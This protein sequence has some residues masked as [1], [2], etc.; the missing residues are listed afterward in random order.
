MAYASSQDSGIG[1]P[2]IDEDGAEASRR[3]SGASYQ[4]IL[5]SRSAE[6]PSI[7]MPSRSREAPPLVRDL[8]PQERVWRERALVRRIDL[9]LL[10]ML[11][12]MYTMNY[13]DRNNIAAARLAG[14]QEELELSSIQYNVPRCLFCLPSCL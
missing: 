6:S 10:P 12:M 4:P 7:A 14:L 5:R 13:L 11:V 3:A 8:L 1:K 2:R 9:R